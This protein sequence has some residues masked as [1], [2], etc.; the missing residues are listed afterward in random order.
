MAEVCRSCGAVRHEGARFCATC[1][2][3]LVTSL[4]TAKYKQVTVLFSDVVRSMDIAAALDPERLRE[5]MTELAERSAAVVQRYGGTVEF[6]GDGVMALFGA[7]I[8]LEDHALRGCLAALAIQAAA[9]QLAVEVA[10]RDGVTLQLRIGLNSGRVIA[11]E[12]GSGTLGYA[13]I[14]APVAFAQRMESVAPPGGVMLSESTARLVERTVTLAEPERVRIKGADEPVWARRLVAINAPN[15]QGERAEASLVGRRW[16]MAVL[17]AM[18]DRAIGGR[19]GVVNVAGPPGI[20]K[21]RAA[22]EV[23]AVAAGRGVEVFWAFCE[24]HTGDIPFHLV[25]QMLRSGTGVSDLDGDDARTQVRAV[26][27]AADPQDL[28]L[29]DDLLGIADTDVPLPQIGPDARRRRLTALINSATLARTAPAL[30]IIEDAHWIDAI[31]ESMLTDFLTVIPRTSSMV[32]ITA[33]PEYVGALT[34]VSGAQSIALVPLA[35]SESAAMLADLLGSDPSVSDLAVV[36]A[37]RASGN[38]F[39]ARRWCASWCSAGCWPASVVAMSVGRM[40]PR[41]A[42]RPRC[43]QPSRRVSTGS[44]RRPDGC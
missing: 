34:R 4:D 17:D 30:Y 16:E 39:F 35:D 12:L 29:L 2:S 22:R 26:M 33:R 3:Q 1:G 21:S 37:D 9:N 10:R 43:R 27:P 42:C 14:G 25:T 32:L 11:G 15:A 36:I 18:V 6:T 40:S 7:P 31:S 5:V 38:P 13:A 19:G 41:S 44:A 28:L 23:A 24:S 20:G 8:A